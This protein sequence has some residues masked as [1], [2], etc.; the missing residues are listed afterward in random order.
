[1]PAQKRAFDDP[2]GPATPS[3]ASAAAA[4]GDARRDKKPRASKKSRKGKSATPQLPL[5]A[6]PPAAASTED[7]DLEEGEVV[8]GDFSDLFVVDTTPAAVRPKDRFVPTEQPGAAPTPS[9]KSRGTAEP[10]DLV[11]Q[12]V[13]TAEGK[14]LPP[15]KEEA[16][17]GMDVDQEALDSDDAMRIFAQ[18]VGMSDD[19]DEDLDDSDSESDEGGN[20]F[21]GGGAGGEGLMLYDDEDSLQKAIQ[22]RIVDDS[23]APATGRYYKEADLTKTCVLCGEH[24]HTSRDCTHS[25]CFVCG[26]ID[27]EHE[28]R[29]CPVSLVCSACGSR[30]H[31]ARDCRIAPGGS[32]GS[33]TQRCQQCGSS[34]HKSTNCPSVWRS[35][36]TSGP[37]PP[38]RKVV[39][40]CANCGNGK[41]HFIDDCMMPRGHPMKHSDPSAFN[42]EALGAAAANLPLPT[43]GPSSTSRRRGGATGKLDMRPRGAGI[44]VEEEAG[45]D[46]WFA[47]RA[48]SGGGGGG[49]AMRDRGRGSGGGGGGGGG[50]RGPPPAFSFRNGGGPVS[51]G[52]GSTHTVFGDSYRSGGSG[53][54][55]GYDDLDRDRDYSARRSGGGGG[56]GSS[57]SGY[58]SP[59][60][61]RRSS[62][63]GKG[64]G[65]GGGGGGDRGEDRRGGPPPSL[66]DRV[67]GGGGGSGGSSRSSTPVHGGSAGGG[68]AGRGPSYRG[69]YM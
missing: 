19:S 30:G 45:D 22:G 40:A 60:D 36:D 10:Q 2:V 28:A 58:D 54:R 16:N 51:G 37:K 26:V 13:A 32:R 39:L 44:R 46:D 35:Y 11:A 63:G 31:F 65:G 67:G 9:K 42:R 7:A 15:T 1:M 34:N 66:L 43:A 14:D 47:S 33:Y 3:S 41:D 50:G 8:E 29:N 25:Q 21:G 18:E 12:P 69:G 55:G 52:R 20:A 49:S 23:S 4:G 56:G 17:G 48:R 38:K 64:S 59:R 24:G 53:R 5:N 6:G 68:R 62:Y 61:D 57:R 27:T